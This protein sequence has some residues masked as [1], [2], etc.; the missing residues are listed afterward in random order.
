MRTTLSIFIAFFILV[1]CI[2]AC[3]YKESVVMA[4][5]KSYI[6]FS[7]RSEGVTA[8]LDDHPPFD[9]APSFYVDSQGDKK[10][11]T[12]PVHYEVEPGKHTI[13]LMRNG[14]VILERTLLLG[15]HMTMEIEIP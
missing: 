8:T 12:A 2:S 4:D 6:W 1:L 15:N 11:K 7:G 3:G 9:L 10:S 13:T 5:T 14:Q